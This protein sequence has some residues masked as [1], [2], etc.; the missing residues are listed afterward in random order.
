MTTEHRNQIFLGKLSK[1]RSSEPWQTIIEIGQVLGIGAW[2]IL[3]VWPDFSKTPNSN[4]DWF[5]LPNGGMLYLGLFFV[6]DAV[7][8]L[9]VNLQKIHAH[10]V[11]DLDSAKIEIA[12]NEREQDLERSKNALG[13]NHPRTFAKELSLLK[14]YLRANNNE[15]AITYGRDLF[16]RALKTLGPTSPITIA[17]GDATSQAIVN[18]VLH[19]RF[20]ENFESYQEFLQKVLTVNSNNLP[21]GNIHTL[22]SEDFLL[23]VLSHGKAELNEEF[24][25]VIGSDSRGPVVDIHD[26]NLNAF[27]TFD[28]NA[29]IRAILTFILDCAL[30]VIAA[31]FRALRVV[32]PIMILRRMAVATE[33][34]PNW[35]FPLIGRETFL[36][37]QLGV[38]LIYSLGLTVLAI[39]DLIYVAEVTGGQ[40]SNLNTLPHAIWYSVQQL[41]LVGS[42]NE[43]ASVSGKVYSV[44]LLFMGLGIIGLFGMLFQRIFGMSFLPKQVNHKDL[45][46]EQK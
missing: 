28:R 36:L 31:P 29:T 2:I 37:L 14:A 24:Q 22:R 32:R 34:E 35:R 19:D 16:D 12:I 4:P 25:K 11:P 40:S 6:I 26:L 18:D 46:E 15:R 41:T 27:D 39:G 13:V 7:L 30:I 44:L 20:K 1:F 17:T 23:A 42:N 10:R 38:L 3:D 33:K 9:N 45:I 21:P 5:S 43:P 8:I